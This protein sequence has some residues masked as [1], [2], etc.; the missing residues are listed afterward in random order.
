MIVTYLQRRPF[1]HD[2][3]IE[4]V[5]STVRRALPS[6][7]ECRVRLCRYNGTNP[8]KVAYN[9]V[10]V[11]MRQA[12]INHIT[13]DI[14]YLTLLLR[15]RSTILTVHDCGN[16]VSLK[17]WRRRLYR[18]WW[19]LLPVRRSALVTVISERTKQ[20]VMQLTGCPEEKIRVV[21]DPVG[22][23][24]Q[25]FPRE[26][27][28]E[29]P[30]ILQVGARDNK[31]L[32]RVAAALR[33]IPCEFHVV[34]RLRE[35]DRVELDRTGIR[36]RISRELTDEQVVRAYEECD[37]VVFASTYEGFGMPIVEA[38]A[39]GR[40]LVTSNLEPMVSVAGGAACLVD[41]YESESI[42]SGVLRV[43]QDSAY[44]EE[45]IRRGFENV[46]RFS[47][48][49][50]AEAYLG[51]YG[52]LA[53]APATRQGE[54]AAPPL[55]SGMM[56][57]L[58]DAVGIRGHGGAAILCDLLY[59]LPRVRPGW[60]WQVVLLPRHLREFDDPIPQEGVEVRYS[61]FGHTAV[62]RLI[63]LALLLPFRA[64][65]I[66]A[67]VVFSFANLPL[68][69]GARPNVVYLHQA[70]ALKIGGHARLKS[71]RTRL[72]RFVILAG[73]RRVR[74]FIVQTQAM[75]DALSA[76]DDSLTKKTV[77]VPGGCRTASPS[78]AVSAQFRNR[79]A[80]LPHPRIAYVSHP[81]EHKN[82]ETLIRAM[83]DV[84]HRM[85]SA[86]LLLTVELAS[87]PDDRYRELAK[88][89]TEVAQEAGATGRI[90]WLG[91]LNGAEVEYLLRDVDVMVFPS[92]AESFG[93]PI[94]EA[95]SANCPVVAADL[96]Y[97]RDVA[98]DAAIYVD[99]KDSGKIADAIMLVLGS[100]DV[101]QGLRVAGTAIRER[102][103][104]PVIANRIA[105]VL[106]RAALC[107]NRG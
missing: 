45:L 34:G 27:R 55:K 21:P 23:E 72:M 88:R 10:D 25:P 76:A 30:V 107:S 54:A 6:W 24:F 51:I 71:L 81:R 60:S 19:L 29:T 104:Y 3:S 9:I 106:E 70:K 62:G 16:S 75:A 48:K 103:S 26:F 15:K 105:A 36:Y 61:R 35:A 37:L 41:P 64:R 39:V 97:A 77:V 17:G 63:W 50:I 52:E 82:H 18:W 32:S 84:A 101:R 8:V 4:R 91:I 2:F 90:A 85:P 66:G 56:T 53:F 22:E 33:G 96:P 11:M 94:A 65:H 73:S 28:A 59:W 95:I 102:F 38:N 68:L 93:L 92:L 31:N 57:I 7:V 74:N 49:A 98:G 5:F 100:E 14:S 1:A 46:K 20:E 58:V 87:P 80:E 79:I 43:I 86:V 13:G 83:A 40:P 42:R 89:L 67:D 99:P 47:P 12:G 44:R 78:D 69:L